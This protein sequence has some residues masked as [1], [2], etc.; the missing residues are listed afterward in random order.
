MPTA[1][2]RHSPRWSP[3]APMAG[4]PPSGRR[5]RRRPRKTGL[6]TGG[7]T[8]RRSWRGNPSF[9]DRSIHHQDL[10]SQYRTS[11]GEGFL[12]PPPIVTSRPAGRS[13]GMGMDGLIGHAHHLNSLLLTYIISIIG[14]GIELSA[15]QGQS[16]L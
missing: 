5:C 7:S 8:T 1:R 12:L 6:V 14:G 16:R 2:G 15:G 10:V 13:R 3:C 4:S 11:E 9:S